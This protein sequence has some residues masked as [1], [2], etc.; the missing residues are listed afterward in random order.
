MTLDLLP[1]FEHF[2]THH[3][4]TGSLRHIYAFNDYPIS[5]EMLLGLGAGVGFI[6]WH[7]T[8]ALP[9]LGGRANIERPGV[10]GL[11]KT[12]GRRTGVQ[13]LTFR[14][15]SASKAEKR[16]LEL[17]QAGQPVMLILDMGYLPYFDFG[18]E[19]FHF[20][21]HVVAACGYDPAS[22][23]VLVAD[24]DEPLHAVPLAALRQARGSTYK[25]FPP[26]HGWHEFDFSQ[27]RP[28]EAAELRQAIQEAARGMLEPPIA[29]VGVK[30]IR[31]AAARI[32]KW[33]QALNE[34]TL[35]EACF[36]SAIMIDA[37]GGT[38]GGL[39]RTMYARFLREAAEYTGL[40]GLKKSAAQMQAVG[41]CWQEAA[42]L[43]E[44]ASQAEQPARHLGEV[45]PLL[46]RLAE[47]EERVW[48]N[49]AS[50]SN[51]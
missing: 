14:T 24:R 16:L 33:P 42:G 32:P 4:I 6:Y 36:N 50:I 29:N 48:S 45:S 19:E 15:N 28:P 18:G 35:R 25:P 3:C 1:G 23:E 38:G 49:L 10:E 30:G 17:L 5:E 44:R 43:F 13:A 46:L 21:Y 2:T 20:G 47:E 9:F 12:V 26:Q 34:K 39:F 27:K 8:G 7:M 31:K 41:D 51:M 37:R 40:D 11:E 22:Q